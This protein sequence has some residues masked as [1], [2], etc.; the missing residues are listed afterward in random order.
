MNQPSRGGR[1]YI[2]PEESAAAPVGRPSLLSI[3]L[4]D[5]QRRKANAERLWTRL[6]RRVE[7]AMR[8]EGL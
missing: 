6:I 4:P 2:I 8:S 7:A 3:I 1:C 5:A